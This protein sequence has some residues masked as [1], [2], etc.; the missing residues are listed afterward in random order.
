MARS[1]HPSLRIFDNTNPEKEVA[2]FTALP[3]FFVDDLMR[4]GTGVPAS[5][6][7]LT[8]AL[9]RGIFAEQEKNAEGKLYHTYEW[10]STSDQFKEKYDLGDLAVQDWTNAY[11]VSG[12]FSIKRGR[13][14]LKADKGTPTVWHYNVHATQ[15]DWIYFIV[16]LRHVLNPADGKRMARHG[17]FEDKDRNKVNAANSFKLKLALEVDHVREEAKP[18]PLRPVNKDKIKVFLERGYGWLDSDGVITWTYRR[19]DKPEDAAKNRD[20]RY[21]S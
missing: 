16:A 15:T 14:H 2:S 9:M 12:L 20:R 7:K 10:K 1:L 6:W 4:I 18:T 5:F 11:S 8:F 19:P 3:N 13:K 21:G 17:E